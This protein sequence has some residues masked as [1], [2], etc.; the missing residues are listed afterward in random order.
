M[1]TWGPNLYQSDL[2]LD[3]RDKY[4]ELLRKGIK[5][6]EIT[7]IFINEYDYAISDVDDVSVFWFALADT[8]WDFGRLEDYVKEKAL[9]Y[10]KTG[11]DISRWET[12]NPKQVNE[13]IKVI[14]ALEK[15]LKTVQP[16]EKK[17]SLYKLY[18]CEWKIGDVY[19]YPLNSDY[20][21]K[22]E[23]NGR[24]L[25]FHKVG[26]TTYYPGHTIP[27]VRIKI[28]TN[29]SL[30]LDEN[31]INQ[32]EY[33]QTAVTKYEDRFLPFDGTRSIEE[34]IAEKSNLQY[35]C[36]EYGFLPHYK[37]KLINI[38]KRSIPKSLIYIGNFLGIKPPNIEFTPH[39]ELNITGFMW[40]YFEK[41]II[42]RYFGYNH[43]QFDIY[44]ERQSGD[45]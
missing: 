31:E 5:G 4:K 44:K 26:E 29:D 42:D 12:D 21:K 22:T 13:R 17:I 8:Q 7:R 41:S 39:S 9:D 32:L 45:G 10:I 2:A 30:P 25:L 27:I 1:S 15:K 34:Q 38:S 3:I 36:D 16:V 11:Y 20:A 40:K 18:H 37:I 6:E 14:T 24:Y 33:V 35:V 23:L 43:R 28:T 19:A